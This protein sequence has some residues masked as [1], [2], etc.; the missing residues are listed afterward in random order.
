MLGHAER[1]GQG[2]DREGSVAVRGIQHLPGEGGYLDLGVG[3][4]LAAAGLQGR[5]SVGLAMF[6][7]DW[8]GIRFQGSNSAD[9]ELLMG[10]A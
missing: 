8:H 3:A 1:L 5:L 7:H 10:W 2:S 9:M 6:R 4:Q